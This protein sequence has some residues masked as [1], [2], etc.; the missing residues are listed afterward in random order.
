MLIPHSYLATFIQIFFVDVLASRQLIASSYLNIEESLL[1]IFEA[2]LLLFSKRN[3]RPSYPLL[4]L[5]VPQPHSSLPRTYSIFWWKKTFWASWTICS[6]FL[7][8]FIILFS[9]A[10]YRSSCPVNVWLKIHSFTNL[11][12]IIS[13]QTMTMGLF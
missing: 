2:L 13:S 12:R 10:I 1:Y 3:F 6:D 9:Y 5:L 4:S 8:Y 7:N 11:N